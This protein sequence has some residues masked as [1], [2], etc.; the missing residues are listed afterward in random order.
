MSGNIR[1]RR[2]TR[3]GGPFE[4]GSTGTTKDDPIVPSD[5]GAQSNIARNEQ[6]RWLDF[7]G[8][9]HVLGDQADLWVG[10]SPISRTG[11]EYPPAAGQL[12]IGEF[13]CGA[14][15]ALW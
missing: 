7:R 14:T 8:A 10:Q 1:S 13:V 11:E 9:L 5:I 3:R 15:A 6:S 4:T 12:R 2:L